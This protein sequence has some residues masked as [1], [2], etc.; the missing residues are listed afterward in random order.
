MSITADNLNLGVLTLSDGTEI[1]DPPHVTDAEGNV[2]DREAT[3]DLHN[4][5]V[6]WAEIALRIA[7][8]AHGTAPE[9]STNDARELREAYAELPVRGKAFAR[10]HAED[11]MRGA[12][13]AGG[14]DADAFTQAIIWN[15][16]ATVQKE[17]PEK[18]KAE[19]RSKVEVSPAE[20]VAEKVA[21]LKLALEYLESNGED[22]VE[23]GEFAELVESKVEDT[24]PELETY[25]DWEM[26]EVE[27]GEEKGEFEGEL[28]ALTREAARLVLK[29]GRRAGASG[30]TGRSWTGPR[31]SP[32][33]H[34]E[35][36]FADK[37]S[38]TF[39]TI[40]EIVAIPSPEYGDDKPSSGAITARLFPKN[41]SACVVEGIE[42][43]TNAEG[44]QG[45][46]KL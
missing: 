42:P 3:A 24:Y 45:A 13:M 14:E 36:A 4:E 39:L 9:V 2:I 46:L 20:R 26:T 15:K 5:I 7:G 16:I 44:R 22:D 41:G 43:G 18:P 27:D 17:T 32:A 8:E 34:I 1:T 19:R 6:A 21:A 25:L 11:R 28:S 10:S 33:A 35:N 40:A 37:D 12:L 30:G 38:G 23:P 31:R 29:K